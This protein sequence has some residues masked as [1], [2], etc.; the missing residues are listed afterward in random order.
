MIGLS[1]VSVDN[2]NGRKAQLIRKNAFKPER[3]LIVQ[4]G[5]SDT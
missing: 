4:E 1:V 3:L 5:N 2:L